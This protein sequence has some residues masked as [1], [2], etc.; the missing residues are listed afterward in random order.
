MQSQQKIDIGRDFSKY[1]GGRYAKNGPHSGQEFRD[2][3]LVPALRDH[4]VVIVELGSAEGYSG[5]FGGLIRAGYSEDVLRQKLRLTGEEEFLPFVDRAW[6][7][8]REE[9]SRRS[10]KGAS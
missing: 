3:M 2:K 7:Y 6:L 1:P 10:A 4:E 5:S 8:V 9:A